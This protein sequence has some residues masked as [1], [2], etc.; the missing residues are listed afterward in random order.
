MLND[1]AN[2]KK[3]WIECLSEPG[4]P[5]RLGAQTNFFSRQRTELETWDATEL[6]R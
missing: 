4:T 2:A 1:R 5:C 6:L 3:F